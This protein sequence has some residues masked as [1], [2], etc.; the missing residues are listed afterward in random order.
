MSRLQV[1]RSPLGGRRGRTPFVFGYTE[2]PHPPSFAGY[3]DSV[4]EPSLPRPA[5]LIPAGFGINFAIVWTMAKLVGRLGLE[6][7]TH[8]LNIVLAARRRADQTI[9]FPLRGIPI[10]VVEPS[11]P[12]AG[13]GCGLS[14]PMDCYPTPTGAGTRYHGILRDPRKLRD[15]QL[16]VTR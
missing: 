8:S 3:P 16:P 10:I 14:A 4:I 11:P 1:L 2:F 9:P 15:S 6:P 12:T 7:S 13:L 5:F